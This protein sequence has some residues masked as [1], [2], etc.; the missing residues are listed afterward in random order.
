MWLMFG[1]GVAGFIGE[2]SA[3]LS[4]KKKTK[5][6]ADDYKE[7]M[8]DYKREGKYKI[9]TDNQTLAFD[10]LIE[11][12]KARKSAEKIRRGAWVA[13]ASLY[14]AAALMATI[15]WIQVGSQFGA[16]CAAAASYDV[17]KHIKSKYDSI[18]TLSPELSGYEYLDGMTSAEFIEI[19]ARKV[20]SELSPISLAHA[21]DGGGDSDYMLTLGP[22]DDPVYINKT[23]GRFFRKNNNSFIEIENQTG[24]QNG[25][26][27]FDSNGNQFVF[28]SN[29]LTEDAGYMTGE[30]VV[31]ACSK[32]TKKDG[33]C[34]TSIIDKFKNMFGKNKMKSP[35]VKKQMSALDK[36][37]ATPYLRVAMNGLLALYARKI[38][39]DAKENMDIAQ[40]RID[41]LTKIRD[42][43]VASGGAGLAM[44]KDDDWDNKEMPQCFCFKPE[45][46]PD[47]KKRN[48]TICKDLVAKFDAKMAKKYG[49]KYGAMDNVKVC[50]DEKNQMDTFCKCKTKKSSTG[51]G[52]AC[53]KI[54]SKM[55]I[56]G[57][58][59]NSWLKGLTA[60]ADSLLNGNLDGSQLNTTDLN[61]RALAIKKNTDKLAKDPKHKDKFRK[62]NSTRAK[63]EKAHSNWVKKSFPNGAPRGLASS[64]AS[65]APLP[66]SAKD[67]LKA[68]KKDAQKA[69]E[70][71]YKDGKPLATGTGDK[72]GDNFDFDWGDDSTGKG[73]VEVDEIAKV[74][75]KNYAIKG[76]I[77][78]N[79]SQDIFKILSIRYQRSGLRRLFDT[80][81]KSI[82]DEANESDINEK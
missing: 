16:A 45:G 81:G 49:W 74:M 80:E 52:N 14:T 24:A 30:V 29:G 76:D 37:L 73:G 70:V 48:L 11:A 59:G 13:S 42:D 71:K 21:Q 41:A 50:V 60:P 6:L 68:A 63:L 25:Q 34:K 27:I 44:C 72:K 58:G 78:N 55:N 26:R 39:K 8:S 65:A 64:F 23:S 9:M 10:Y 15:E 82:A 57:L 56:A 61:K 77:N 46:G 47:A 36:A 54:S 18:A 66:T 79:P 4:Y 38:A 3:Q 7:K 20:M 43:F 22:E 17:D 51:K 12:E 75:D 69:S 53:T 2:M 33:T 32:G 1:G 28:G 40:N 19:I 62:I 35:A 5:N 31:T 67:V